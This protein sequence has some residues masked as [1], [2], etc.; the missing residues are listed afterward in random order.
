MRGHAQSQESPAPNFSFT[1][2]GFAWAFYP[3]CSIP[4]Q[5]SN[6]ILRNAVGGRRICLASTWQTLRFTQGDSW[7]AIVP[8]P[9]ATGEGYGEGP[10]SPHTKL[11]AK[12]SQAESLSAREHRGTLLQE[13]LDGLFMVFGFPYLFLG[14]VGQ[15]Q[16]FL[17][18][19]GQAL[20][21]QVLD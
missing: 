14:H 15:V 20:V 18:F 7:M 9:V 5:L 16:R 13:R 4:P 3:L 21:H 10:V 11:L 17:E 1:E 6:V 12:I 8:S 19:H 2:I